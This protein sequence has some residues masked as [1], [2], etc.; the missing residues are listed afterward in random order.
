MKKNHVP[1]VML[2]LLVL[3]T[4]LGVSSWISPGTIVL[5]QQEA[6]ATPPPMS[7]PGEKSWILVD[8]PADATQL[9]YGT[10]VYR[11]VCKACHGDKG[12]GLTD[13]W[14]AQWNP[15]DQNC[16]QSKCHALNH[17]PDG[18]YMPQVPAVVGPPLAIFPTALDLYNYIHDFMPWHD[19]GS[20]TTK[21]SW[22]V[23]AYILK[24]NGVDPGTDLNPETA[25]RISLGRNVAAGSAAG[26]ATQPAPAQVQTQAP[27]PAEEAKSVGAFWKVGLFAAGALVLVGLYFL[28][29]RLMLGS[30]E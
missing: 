24:I 27:A 21:D 7:T 30:R 4:T 23:T 16:W 18:F 29:R 28:I 5:L 1:A 6:T 26:P 14:R 22:T 2:S 17:P 3:V 10:E 13:D 19:R 20:M 15:R 12:Q 8:L 25:A 11:L 9:E